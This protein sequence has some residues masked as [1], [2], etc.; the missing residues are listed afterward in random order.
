MPKAQPVSIERATIGN[1][2]KLFLSAELV[3]VN[4]KI[5]FTFSMHNKRRIKGVR[6]KAMQK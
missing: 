6:I 1:M 4:A 5:E 2:A 3:S